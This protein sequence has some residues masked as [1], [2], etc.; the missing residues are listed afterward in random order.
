MGRDDVPE[1]DVLLEPELGQNAVDDRRA[2]LGGPA[3]GELARIPTVAREVYDVVGAGL[4][5]STF[6]VLGYVFWQ[7]FSQLVDYAK[8]GALALGA[9]IVLVTAPHRAADAK[10]QQPA[11]RAV[12]E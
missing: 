6:V 2:G 4:W 11:R 5:G 10:R 3:A 12:E 8:K 9:V 1:Q 7:S